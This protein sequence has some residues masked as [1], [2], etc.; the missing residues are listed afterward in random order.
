ML[1]WD[2]YFASVT[3]MALHPGFTR[4]GGKNFTI[5]E[6]ADI[7]DQ[8]LIEREKRWLSLPGQSSQV[9]PPL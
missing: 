9:E 5:A 1:V 3:G 2:V 7:A 6:C 4:D 8:M